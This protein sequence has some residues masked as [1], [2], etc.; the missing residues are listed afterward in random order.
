MSSRGEF[1]KVAETKGY[2][3]DI[4]ALQQL[5][6]HNRYSPIR[7]GFTEIPVGKGHG[8][9]PLSV[10]D[11]MI[12]NQAGATKG[13]RVRVFRSDDSGNNLQELF[14]QRLDKR[15]ILGVR[16]FVPHMNAYFG[17]SSFGHSAF[18]DDCTYLSWL[19]RDGWRVEQ[20]E[21]CIRDW[22]FGSRLIHSLKGALYV[23]HHT[24]RK[25]HAK[26]YIIT[27]GQELPLEQ[28]Q[29]RGSS[30]SPDGCKIAYGLGRYRNGNRGPRQRLRVFNYCQYQGKE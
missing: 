16:R 7:C 3:V 17:N 15:G 26:S 21:L 28:E 5:S 29:I 23:E 18:S 19:Y 8:F 22:A 20:E 30:V 9:I 1:T 25:R 10:A 6:E 12:K 2:R 13:D 4:R 24:D 11:G 27:Q 14:G